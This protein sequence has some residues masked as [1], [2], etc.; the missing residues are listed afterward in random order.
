[1][2]I[3]NSKKKEERT[4]KEKISFVVLI[5]LNDNCNKK[6]Y[7]QTLSKICYL[8]AIINMKKVI[9]K[10]KDKDYWSTYY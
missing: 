10:S 1:M 3:R 6:S 2:V 9:N 5:L 8:C 4:T 7:Q